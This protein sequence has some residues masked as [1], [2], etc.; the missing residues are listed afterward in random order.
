MATSKIKIFVS[1]PFTGKSWEKVTKE[2]KELH[3]LAKS[4]GMEIVE[5]FIGYQGKDDFENK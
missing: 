1:A 3:K 2:R 4:F 5:Q